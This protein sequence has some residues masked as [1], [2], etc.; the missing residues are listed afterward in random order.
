MSCHVCYLT[1]DIEFTIIKL[2]P[3]IAPI[4]KRP[5]GMR[6]N[7]LE[8]LKRQIRRVTRSWII[9]MSKVQWNQYLEAQ[10]LGE[11][12]EDLRESYPQLFVYALLN[13]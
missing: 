8:E 11:R 9:K 12:E 2:L 3:G 5:Y 13:L 7:E 10:A 1:R 6:I 4:A